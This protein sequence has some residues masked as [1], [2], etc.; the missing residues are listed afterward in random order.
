MELTKEKELAAEFKQGEKAT[1]QARVDLWKGEIRPHYERAKA[2][3]P[4]IRKP[5]NEGLQFVQEASK[6]D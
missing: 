6:S 4:R 2:E 1:E 3:I 5:C